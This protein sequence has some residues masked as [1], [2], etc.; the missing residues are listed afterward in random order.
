MA[1][2]TDRPTDDNI[3]PPHAPTARPI[4]PLPLPKYLGCHLH[5]LAIT[6]YRPTPPPTLRPLPSG[7]DPTMDPTRHPPVARLRPKRPPGLPSTAR[8]NEPSTFTTPE[9]SAPDDELD[10]DAKKKLKIIA[11]IPRLPTSELVFALERTSRTVEGPVRSESD[12]YRWLVQLKGRLEAEIALRQ[13]QDEDE[14]RDRLVAGPSSVAASEPP[15]QHE[16][17]AG[18]SRAAMQAQPQKHVQS[19]R[20]RLPLKHQPSIVDVSRGVYRPFPG[21]SLLRQ[22]LPNTSL[23]TDLPLPRRRAL[24]RMRRDLASKR[25]ITSCT[26]CEWA[27]RYTPELVDH[28]HE[29][30]LDIKWK[31]DYCGGEERERE[32]LAMH[33]GRAHGGMVG[34]FEEGKKWRVSPFTVMGWHV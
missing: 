4:I 24:D 18:T 3:N 14:Q 30:H 25:T 31:C 8:P 28:V 5:G 12:Q 20:I 2:T 32:R 16:P 9:S 34:E 11:F 1:H 7:L 19:K 6:S 33:V 23:E 22:I 26:M 10:T 27:G 29:A 21:D 17:A 15:A 13:Q